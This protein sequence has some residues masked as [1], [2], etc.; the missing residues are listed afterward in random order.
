MALGPVDFHPEAVAE[1]RAAL[2]WYWERSEEAANS[3]LAEL[4]NAVEQIAEAP[5]RWPLY[6]HTRT[7]S[8]YVGFPF[9]WPIV[10]SVRL[11]RSSR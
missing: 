3:F 4:D 9:L 5:R 8:F 7:V 10:K 2:D 11:C 6:L 1:A